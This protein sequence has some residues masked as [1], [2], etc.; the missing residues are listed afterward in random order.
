[1]F[2][3]WCLNSSDL[4]INGL[5]FPFMARGLECPEEVQLAWLELGKATYSSDWGALST[6]GS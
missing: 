1:M 5:T 6:C 4:H 3:Q 2:Y